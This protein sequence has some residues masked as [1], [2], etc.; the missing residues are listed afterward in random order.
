MMIVQIYI[1]RLKIM[2]LEPVSKGFP[3]LGKG[4]S[5]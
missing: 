1:M 3:Y 2:L 4:V 5:T